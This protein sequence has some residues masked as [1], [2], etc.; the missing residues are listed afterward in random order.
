MATISDVFKSCY[1]LLI[2][3]LCLILGCG[4]IYLEPS[5]NISSP[6][7]PGNYGNSQRC[8]WEL[9][10]P[11]DHV[12]RISFQK[13]KIEP[14]PRCFY[15]YVLIYDNMTSADTKIMGR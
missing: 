12:I 5:G 4:G 6:N 2:M 14:H 7:F 3:F 11:A 13:F 15:D 1:L 10:A 9:V 8:V